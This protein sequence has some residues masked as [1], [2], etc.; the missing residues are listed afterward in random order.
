M[1]TLVEADGTVSRSV[2]RQRIETLLEAKQVFWLDVLD[3]GADD[4]ALFRDGFGFH[5]LAV[6]DSQTF[7]QRSKLDDYGDHAFLVVFG[8]APDDDGLVEV[9]CFYTERFLVTVRRDDAPAIDTLLSRYGERAPLVSPVRALYRIVD[10]L[11]DSFFPAL[12][13]FDDR[14]DEIQDALLRN[15][16]ESDLHDL[17]AMRRRLITLRRVVVGERDVMG[18]VAGGLASLPGVDTEGE[19]FFRNVYDHLLRLSETIDGYRDLTATVMDLYLSS[20]SNRMNRV[21]TQLTLIATIFLPLTFVTGFFGQNFGWLVDHV[22]SLWAFAT[23]G[24]LMEL[25]VVA[26]LFVWFR[27]RHWV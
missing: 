22:G 25:V 8:W 4:F 13:D 6:E 9:H 23:L 19:H 5:P 15:P 12:E 27:R 2:G 21:I 16:E 18:R 11:V 20:A 7:D 26:A 3:P 10:E 1:T 24:V 17:T 14:L